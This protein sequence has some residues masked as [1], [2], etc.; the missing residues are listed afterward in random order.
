MLTILDVQKFNFLKNKSNMKELTPQEHLFVAKYIESN[1]GT[2]SVIDS[3]FEG[4][5][6]SAGIKASRLL[7]SDK[8]CKQIEEFKRQVSLASGWNKARVIAEVEQVYHASMQEDSHQTALKSLELISRLCNFM[9]EKNTTI[10]VSHSFES[11]LKRVETK[12]V[13]PAGVLLEAV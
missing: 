9:P 6:K 4:T 11:L 5:R 13:T 8:I 1:N 12:D 2:Q 3:G 7:K 10:A